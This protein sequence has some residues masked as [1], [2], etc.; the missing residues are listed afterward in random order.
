LMAQ[1]LIN[2]LLLQIPIHSEIDVNRVI[3]DPMS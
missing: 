3:L 1:H 2:H